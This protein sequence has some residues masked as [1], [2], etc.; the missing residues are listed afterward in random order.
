MRFFNSLLTL[1]SMLA[2]MAAALSSFF[3]VEPS[4]QMFGIDALFVAMGWAVFWMLAFILPAVIA[5]A[6]SVARAEYTYSQ[7]RYGRDVDDGKHFDLNLWNDV[8]AG[9]HVDVNAWNSPR[10]STWNSVDNP[11]IYGTPADPINR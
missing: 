5:E 9:Q 10:N 3:M 1:V 4:Q 2:R 6:R 11:I 8:N 7:Y